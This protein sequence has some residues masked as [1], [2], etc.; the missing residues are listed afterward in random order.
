MY[1]SDTVKTTAVANHQIISD[2]GGK[3]WTISATNLNA[4]WCWKK[5]HITE[6]QYT[7]DHKL[8]THP[9]YSIS[10]DA[11][12]CSAYQDIPQNFIELTVYYRV[13]GNVIQWFSEASIVKIH[14][15]IVA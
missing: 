8:L 4:V 7:N 3:Y 5:M 11:N 6:K 1:W 10:C 9:V 14:H 13:H 12:G 2:C 15:E